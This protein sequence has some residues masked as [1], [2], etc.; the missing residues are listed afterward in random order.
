V[1]FWPM[2]GIS[3]ITGILN[4]DSWSEGPRPEC[5]R[6]LGLS[7]EPAERMISLLARTRCSGELVLAMYR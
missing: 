2:A 5:M 3:F 7:R 1:R 4:W 6:I